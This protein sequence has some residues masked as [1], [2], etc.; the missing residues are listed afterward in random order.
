MSVMQLSQDW[1]GG[2]IVSVSPVTGERASERRGLT[3]R[4]C[5]DLDL[6]TD[7]TRSQR[8]VQGDGCR[9][10]PLTS[11]KAAVVKSFDALRAAVRKNRPGAEKADAGDHGLDDA[12]RI[13]ANAVRQSDAAEPP[14]QSVAPTR[15][16]M[17]A[18]DTCIWVRKP[19][20]LLAAPV[21]SR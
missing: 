5:A 4:I 10:W 18:Q 9:C 8:L 16:S 13:G 3:R 15:P 19:S 14:D 11:M 7:F 1:E 17:A 12:D 21:R 20:G 2:G 6:A